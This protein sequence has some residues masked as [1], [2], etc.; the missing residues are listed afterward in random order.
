MTTLQ[1]RAIRPVLVFGLGLGLVL[2][3]CGPLAAIPSSTEVGVSKVIGISAQG[4]AITATRYGSEAAT[5][6]VVVVG[7]MHGN[8]RAGRRVTYEIARRLSG[9]NALPGDS[10]IWIISSMNPD[11]AAANTRVTASGVDLNRNFPND[12]LQQGRGSS[13]WSGPRAGS[14]PEAKAV[15]AFLERTDPT[16]L[17]SFHQPFAVVDLTHPNSRPAGQ[18]LATWLRLPAKVV[19]C[20]GP[21]HGTMTGWV[22]GQ[23]GA[24]ALTVELPKLVTSERVVRS[25]TAVLRLTKWLAR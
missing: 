4:R 19:G 16:A 14:E 17:V 24:I 13:S 5:T 3:L 9:R 25:A 8:E 23:L 18:R 21:C 1:A 6:R 12:W 20:P 15:T 11:G 7:Q 2:G 10:A 22:D